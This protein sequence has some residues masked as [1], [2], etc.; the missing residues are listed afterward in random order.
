MTYRDKMQYE[1]LRIQSFWSF[2][3][4]IGMSMIYLARNGFYYTGRSTECRCYFCG[5]T[6]NDWEATDN[7]SERIIEI[8][9]RISPNCVFLTGSSHNNVPIHQE[10]PVSFAFGAP[11]PREPRTAIEGSVQSPPGA[12]S[13][14]TGLSDHA[15]ASA[16]AALLPTFP[17]SSLPAPSTSTSGQASSVSSA[18]V[19]AQSST[20]AAAMTNQPLAPS[21]T[22]SSSSGLPPTSQPTASQ[23]GATFLVEPSPTISMPP[24]SSSSEPGPSDPLQHAKPLPQ[25]DKLPSP[26]QQSHGMFTT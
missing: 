13:E 14:A 15:Q 9:R 4:N 20:A 1:W 12:T 21:V 25:R 18:P 8:H 6:Y 3:I 5:H 26:G 19:S 17:A 22:A 10:S 2:P 7:N 11:P 24:A 23:S 16:S